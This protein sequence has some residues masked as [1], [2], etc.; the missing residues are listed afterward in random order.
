MSV[1]LGQQRCLSHD[2]GPP[3]G[4]SSVPSLGA[5]EALAGTALPMSAPPPS[6]RL[7]PT[8]SVAGQASGV[9]TVIYFVEEVVFIGSRF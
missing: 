5:V 3:T 2:S 9:V 7:G 6:G 1:E 8:A 4:Q